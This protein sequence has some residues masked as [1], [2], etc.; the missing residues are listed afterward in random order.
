M[1][2]ILLSFTVILFVY[3]YRLNKRN[4]FIILFSLFYQLLIYA[5]V[6]YN[7]YQRANTLIFMIMF[8]AWTQI[9]ENKEQ[10]LDIKLK[11]ITYTFLLLSV[12]IGIFYGIYDVVVDYSTAYKVAYYINENVS[13]DSVIIALD[14]SKVAA[15]LPYA[16]NYNFWS[17][18]QEE[19]FKFSIWNRIWNRD[20]KEID[21]FKDKIKRNFEEDS[22]LYLINS[23]SCTQY[24]I[25]YN[26][27]LEKLEK[28]QLIKK[29]YKTNSAK[30]MQD[31]N[32]N[33]Y[34]I[35][36]EFFTK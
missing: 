15:I 7:S 1:S 10:V 18:F 3:E 23:N 26:K 11:V 6:W 29:V 8:I 4:F 5:M 32:Y 21:V 31:E 20:I 28:D 34:K 25:D 24:Q 36:K 17:I 33:V 9:E 16:E 2:A 35:E 22:S 12:C 14:D 19:Y 27:I 30:V 13:K